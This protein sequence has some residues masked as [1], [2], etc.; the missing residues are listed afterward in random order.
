[1]KEVQ[2]INDLI[3]RVME[4][5]AAQF[6]E[7]RRKYLS[8]RIQASGELSNNMASQVDRQ[9][10]ADGVQLL[11]SFPDHGRFIDMRRLDR[12]EGGEELVTAI[13][14][15]IREKGQEAKMVRKFMRKHGLKTVPSDVINRIAWGIVR[16]P[17]K[18]RRRWYNKPKSGAITDLYNMVAEQLPD[19]VIRQQKAIHSLKTQ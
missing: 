4:E 8:E 1:M 3:G 9:A 14:D 16:S 19:E 6:I 12:A 2:A 18:R 5:W 7:R 10:R 15:W 11:M 17:R 13:E